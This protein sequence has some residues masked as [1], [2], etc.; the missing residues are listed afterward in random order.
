MKVSFFDLKT[1]HY[2]GDIVCKT[3]DYRERNKVK[4]NDL[5]DLLIGLKN[6]E[7]FVKHKDTDEEK[8]LRKFFDQI[9][10]TAMMEGKT[11]LS[12]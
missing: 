6:D 3:I 2:F 11:E 7:A 9:G 1:Q 10:A 12:K 4:R 8:D 5:L